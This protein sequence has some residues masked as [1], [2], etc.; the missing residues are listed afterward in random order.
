MWKGAKDGWKKQVNEG[1][2]NEGK[3]RMGEKLGRW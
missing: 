2:G 1:E 3:Q